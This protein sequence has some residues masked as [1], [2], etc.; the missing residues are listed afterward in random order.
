MAHAQ[1]RQS[2]DHRVDRDSGAERTYERIAETLT[3]VI[4]RGLMLIHTE[5]DATKPTRI[6]ARP[7]PETGFVRLSQILAVIPYGKS[8]WWAGVKS[9]RFPKP[10]KLSVRRT[11]W[12]AE[13]VHALIKQLSGQGVVTN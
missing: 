4:E 3:E 7:I 10:V 12:R 1:E 5:T 11:A 9:G 13:D 2:A 8:T 6:A